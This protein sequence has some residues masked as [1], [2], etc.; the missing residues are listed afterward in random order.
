[1]RALKRSMLAVGLPV[2]TGY[3]LFAIYYSLIG[4]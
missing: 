4:A 2:A 3:S 1:M